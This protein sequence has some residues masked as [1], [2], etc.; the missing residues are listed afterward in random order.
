MATS[1]QEMTMFKYMLVSETRGQ[2]EFRGR[3]A[4]VLRSCE[5]GQN[6]KFGIRMMYNDDSLCIEWYEGKNELYA[7]D[8]AENYVLGIKNYI[9]D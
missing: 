1:Y 8:A 5:R 9:R 4:E 6:A 2:G 7:E 3:K